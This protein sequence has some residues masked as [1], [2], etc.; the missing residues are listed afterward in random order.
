MKANF[1]LCVLAA[2][3]FFARAA[4]ADEVAP[5]LEGADL[6]VRASLALGSLVA[7]K[8]DAKLRGLYAAFDGNAS[9]ASVM[10]ACD[11]DGDYIIVMSD[12]MLRLASFVAR[13]SV[14]D[15]AH[16]THKLD[17]YAEHLAKNQ[18]AGKR[19]LPPAAGAYAADVDLSTQTRWREIVLFLYARELARLRAG[20]L[21]CPHPTATKERGDGEWTAAEQSAAIAAAHAVYPAKQAER[22]ASAVAEV[23]A[24]GEELTGS[25]Q[26]LP[27]LAHLEAAGPRVTPTYLALHPV[28]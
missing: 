8:P 5:A 15:E 12:A 3:F 9:D 2:A 17:A 11:D 28:R 13:L 1:L 6:R 25:Q 18:A 21:V 23:R 10:A 4:A 20:D 7:A 27:F 26:L 14:D 22:D 24:L 19:L 16:G